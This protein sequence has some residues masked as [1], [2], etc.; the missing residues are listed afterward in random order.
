MDEH[1]PSEFMYEIGA[2]KQELEL[3][4][5]SLLK[6]QRLAFLDLSLRQPT[7]S[8][9]E[10]GFYQVVSWLYCFYYEA[11]RVSFPFL[12]EHFPAYDLE[13]PKEHRDHYERV[14]QLRTQLQHNLNLESSG[15]LDLQHRCE[16]WYSM[17]CGS[18][19]PGNEDEWRN[20]LLSLLRESQ[21]LLEV[22]IDC[23]REIEK[24]ESK[25][26]VVEQW[27]LQIRRSHSPHEFEKLVAIAARD[28]GQ[29][30]LDPV[31]ICDRY[32]DKWSRE[33]RLRTGDYDFVFEARKLIEHT[34]LTDAELPLP[35][36]GQDIIRRFGI[37]PGQ[38]VGRLLKKARI[39][40]ID[41]P[42]PQEILIERLATN[43]G[44]QLNADAPPG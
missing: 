18:A 3:R 8:P 32:Y 39:L 9:S 44:L 22:A 41:A 30:F 15:D 42:C 43:E 40:Y 1:S 11:G 27:L 17:H 24:D 13:N 37:P 20:C 14:R 5:A 33:L 7:F 21:D 31:R 34:L 26:R 2:L 23:V 29:D 35:I 12:L 16:S 10:L 36:T 38:E 6:T 19:I 28:M 25:E 4:S